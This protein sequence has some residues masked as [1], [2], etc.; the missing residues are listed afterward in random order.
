MLKALSSDTEEEPSEKA[1]TDES[2]APEKDT[3]AASVEEALALLDDEFDAESEALLK[4]M[5]S[6]VTMAHMAEAL[7]TPNQTMTDF[8]EGI[9]EIFLDQGEQ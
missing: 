4:E 3:E 9:E 2:A 7:E 8:Y 1:E 6:G 5:A